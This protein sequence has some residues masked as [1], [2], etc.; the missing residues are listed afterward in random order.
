[1]AFVQQGKVMSKSSKGSS[2][3][4]DICRQLSLWWSYGQRDDLYWRC[5]GSGAMAKTRSK[6]GKN[7]FG[8]YGD[9]QAT[10]PIGQPLLDVFTI[11]V[12]RGYS[13]A[14][15]MNMLDKP[16]SAAMQVWESFFQQVSQDSKNAK[17][18]SWMIIWR[19]DRKQALVYMPMT[20]ISSPLGMYIKLTFPH[21][22]GKVELKDGTLLRVFICKLDDFLDHIKPCHIESLL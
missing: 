21:L 17:S 4:R 3:E 8:Q 5:A 12:K 13:S 20:I 19:R 18:K 22:K 6:V 11:E 2:F 16:D 15:F 7:T 1:M 10:D 9:I 14:S